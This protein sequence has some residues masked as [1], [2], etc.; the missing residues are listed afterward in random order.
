MACAGA[1]GSALRVVSDF[2]ANALAVP[3]QK[4]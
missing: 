1:M 2:A 4:S 3:L